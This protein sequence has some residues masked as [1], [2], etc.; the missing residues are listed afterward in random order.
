[1]GTQ[2]ISK[3]SIFKENKTPKMK[4][5]LC[6]ENEKKTAY[7]FR[8]LFEIFRRTCHTNEPHRRRVF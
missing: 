8:N 6:S 3:I 5:C 2:T 7:I 1:M 4:I